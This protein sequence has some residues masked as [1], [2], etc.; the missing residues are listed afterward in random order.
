MIQYLVN[1]AYLV[2]ALVTMEFVAWGAHKYVMH[3]WGWR[4]HR[5]HH[6]ATEGI[7]EKND[8]Y[9][10]VFAALS[11]AL[12]AWGAAEKTPA[13]WIG[14]GMTFYGFLYF[15]VHDG[16]VHKRWPFRYIPRSGYLK[17]LYQ[18]HRLH[19]AV[20]GRDGCVAFGFLLSPP[21]ATLRDALRRNIQSGRASVSR[22]AS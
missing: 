4:W 6:E 5:S 3:G 1:A 10:V 2:A 18:A 8:L 14:L 9:A 22:R 13:Y 11:I 19:H 20:R 17:R 21:V 7:F 16:M 12:I 15:M